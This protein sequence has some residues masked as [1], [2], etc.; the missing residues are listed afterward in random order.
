MQALKQNLQSLH[1]S[2]LLGLGQKSHQGTSGQ[3][4][5]P[6]TALISVLARRT[7]CTGD[8]DADESQQRSPTSC[9]TCRAGA[10]LPSDAELTS[11][12]SWPWKLRAPCHHD[13][14]A[15]Q[16]QSAFTAPTLD[17]TSLLQMERAGKVHH[18][19]AA[20]RAVEGHMWCA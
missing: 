5:A 13:W 11:R 1:A 18:C 12:A 20:V 3:Q 10:M 15:E 9:I 2:T 8:D 17:L 14:T 16:C 19:M 6:F 4:L 7:S